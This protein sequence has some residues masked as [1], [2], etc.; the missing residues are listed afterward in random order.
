VALIAHDEMKKRMIDFAIDHEDE[1]NA[2]GR[3]IATGTTGREVAAATSR[4]IENKL[5]RCHSGPH[6]GD[7]EL[8]TAILYGCCDLVIFFVDPLCCRRDEGGGF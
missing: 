6:G 5:I 1:L 7:I 8:A 3:I 4:R 2:F